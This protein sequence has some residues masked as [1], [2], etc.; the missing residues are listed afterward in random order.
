MS[1]DISGVFKDWD[2]DPSGV[3]ARL[4]DGDDG[5]KKIQ[6]RLDLGVFQMELSGRPDGK[7]PHDF[8]SLLDRYRFLRNTST[9]PFHLTDDDC[10]ELQQEAVQFYYRYLACFAIREY[11][12]VIRDTRHN[13][14]ILDLI[15]KYGPSDA[16]W[17]Y[18]QFKPYV[19]MMESR[20]LAEKAAQGENYEKAMKEVERG[21]KTIRKF[22]EDQRELELRDSSYEIDVLVDLL[23]N[24]KERKPTREI[25]KLRE[26]LQYAISTEDY[27]RAASLRD[28]IAAIAERT[29]M[30]DGAALA[31][32]ASFSD[33]A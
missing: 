15:T 33:G 12:S 11:E 20:A 2:Y 16:V 27:E 24:L 29:A 26:R 14:E 23:D 5:Q 3:T 18:L 8:E 32:G 22:W 28:Q 1:Q 13:L 25:G 9:K 19:L 10:A 21:L 7:R 30:T 31:D 4:I 6:M 17:E